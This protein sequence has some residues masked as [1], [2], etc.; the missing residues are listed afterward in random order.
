[1]VMGQNDG[2][3]AWF[4]AVTL[5]AGCFASGSDVGPKEHRG[6]TSER[7]CIPYD[8]VVAAIMLP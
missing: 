2:E 8:R 5:S 6:G 3:T 4:I 7:Y 1:M